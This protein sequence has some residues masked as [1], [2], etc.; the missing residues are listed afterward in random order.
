MSLINNNTTVTPA[1]V[2][3]RQ[4]RLA[5]LNASMLVPKR[6]GSM[7]NVVESIAENPLTE[8]LKEYHQRLVAGARR[9]DSCAVQIIAL[10]VRYCN[11]PSGELYTECRELFET[12]NQS[13]V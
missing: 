1:L 5:H 3:R 7:D 11:Y 13:G 4:Y 6:G 10:Y 8:L 2:R 9:N 12:W